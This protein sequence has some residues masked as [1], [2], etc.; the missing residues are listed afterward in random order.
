MK[1]V[2]LIQP[3]HTYAPARGPG[4]IYL[5]SSLLAAGSR[6]LEAGIEVKIHDLNMPPNKLNSAIIGINLVGAPYIPS[7]IEFQKVARRRR[8]GVKFLLGGQVVSG[9]SQSQ[10]RGLF[11]EDSIN[12]NDDAELIKFLGIQLKAPEQTSLIPGYELIPDEQMRD[13][14]SGEINLYVSQGCQFSCNFC[15]A[16][17]TTTDSTGTVNRVRENYRDSEIVEDDLTYLSNRAKRLGLTELSIYMSNLD[18]FQRPRELQGFAESVKRVRKETDINIRL[19]GLSTAKSFLFARNRHSATIESLI[20]AGLHTVGFG[21]DGATPEVWKRIGKPIN[22]EEN[23][24]EAIRST[25]QDYTLIPETIMV[26]G[27]AGVDT[28]ESLERS[29]EFTQHTIDK[30]GAVPRPQVAKSFVP[31][32]D[33]W[34]DPKN[35]HAISQFLD[36]PEFFQ[37]LDFNALPSTLTHP[38]TTL[39]EIT[40]SHYLRMAALPGNTTLVVKPIEPGMTRAQKLEVKRFNEGKYDR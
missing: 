27:H 13:Y 19:R 29:Y 1:S 18:V 26:F 4:H 35:A 3:R 36:Q 39:R 14:L 40:A 6:L 31:G 8:R 9:L 17:R 12:G 32:N 38:D 30:F 22:D 33:G 24:L 11:K 10:F 16:V 15:S 28:S 7:A 37:N 20:E 2:D 34:N 21:V 5:P 23:C 25:R